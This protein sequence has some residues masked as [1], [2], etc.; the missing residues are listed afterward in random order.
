MKSS[1]LVKT[2]TNM[3]KE[4]QKV[5]TT[6]KKKLQTIGGEDAV[7]KEKIRDR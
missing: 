7:G 1:N 2:T 6:S 3:K 4:K 5:E